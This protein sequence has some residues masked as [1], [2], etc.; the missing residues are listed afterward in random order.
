MRRLVS[1]VS[2]GVML[3]AGSAPAGAQTAS[4]RAD[5]RNQRYQIG[6]MERVLEGAVEHG[7]DVTRDR[8]QALLPAELL[9]SE[10]A[11][12]RGFR[13][14]GYG[15]FFDV[16][17]PMLGGTLAWSFRTLDHNN[18]GLESAV[19]TLRSFVEKVG[20][21]N[22]EQALKRI[23][24]QIAPVALGPP[25]A[26]PLPTPA[27]PPPPPASP[28]PTAASPRPNAPSV[29]TAR[30][31]T[32]SAAA[33]TAPSAPPGPTADPI[34]D[35]PEEAYRAEVRNALMDAMLE[36]SR[37]LQLAPGEM[38]TVAARGNADR[39]GLV[40]VDSRTVMISLRGADLTAFLAGQISREE[41]RE[42]MTVRVF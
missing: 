17:V 13:L 26:A 15:M 8:L 33:T 9:L 11:R 5:Q 38:L 25:P 21:V 16:A 35:D 1:V 31:V 18:L 28:R 40:D 7:A 2:A 23:E 4:A 6:M 32:G 37:G 20:D 39:L 30:T 19:R 29:A 36:H 41:A 14:E 12:V 10:H 24:L 3:C 22:F 42:R 27:A 34:L